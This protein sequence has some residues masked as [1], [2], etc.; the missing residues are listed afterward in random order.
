MEKTFLLRAALMFSLSGVV[1]LGFFSLLSLKEPRLLRIE[2]K[3][4]EKSR[5]VTISSAFIY[6]LLS[7]LFFCLLKRAES[8]EE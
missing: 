3:Y 7:I 2:K 6:L 5:I 8:K 1:I 4:E